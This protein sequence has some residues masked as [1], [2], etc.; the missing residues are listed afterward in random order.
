MAY[1]IHQRHLVERYLTPLEED[2]TARTVQ[3]SLT[4]L[5]V[6]ALHDL[7]KH[8]GL[9]RSPDLTALIGIVGSGHVWVHD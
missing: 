5:A 9:E 4:H 2:N 3:A 1:R 6:S 7:T 8:L